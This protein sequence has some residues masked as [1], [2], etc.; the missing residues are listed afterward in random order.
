MSDIPIGKFMGQ[1][2]R[3]QQWALDLVSQNW[4]DRPV[5][6]SSLK[7]FTSGDSVDEAT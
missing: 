7:V 4:S 1:F 5:Q 6:V 3:S 2:L